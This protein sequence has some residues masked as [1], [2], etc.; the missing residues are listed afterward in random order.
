MGG[1][2]TSILVGVMFFGRGVQLLFFF[3]RGQC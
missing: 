2:L 1:G 3:D